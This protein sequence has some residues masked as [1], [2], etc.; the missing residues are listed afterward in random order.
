MLKGGILF[1][2]IVFWSVNGY[3]E[4]CPIQF[5]PNP[6]YAIQYTIEN[7]LSKDQNAKG[8][9][10]LSSGVGE[11]LIDHSISL[12]TCV[13]HN[14]KCSGDFPKI[15]NHIKI[16]I[17]SVGSNDVLHFDVES[18]QLKTEPTKNEKELS[19]SK[20]ITDVVSGNS[21][22]DFEHPIKIKIAME[23]IEISVKP[24]LE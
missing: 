16:K 6:T 18:N 17:S 5:G 21:N 10:Y 9:L 12:L 15:G 2:G 24:C 11:S 8:N 3:A 4:T 20:I 23:N 1:C 14:Q 13:D 22:I 7:N 19:K